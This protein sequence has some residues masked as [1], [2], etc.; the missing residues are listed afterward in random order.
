MVSKYL[1]SL[2]FLLYPA[3]CLGCLPYSSV[4]CYAI[5]FRSVRFSFSEMINKNKEVKFN[6]LVQWCSISC[7]FIRPLCLHALCATVL[8]LWLHC[9][10]QPCL[11]VYLAFATKFLLMSDLLS[12]RLKMSPCITGSLQTPRRTDDMCDV[13]EV[14]SLHGK[15]LTNTSLNVYPCV[16]R[17]WDPFLHTAGPWLFTHMQCKKKLTC[18]PRGCVCVTSLFTPRFLTAGSWP[19]HRPTCGRPPAWVWPSH[20]LSSGPPC[21]C[22]LPPSSKT[23]VGYGVEPPSMSLLFSSASTEILY[24]LA[25]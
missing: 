20:C 25:W 18:L 17:H 15:F 9:V 12:A 22:P 8:Q 13:I 21:E 5:L 4:M 11:S 16:W 24:C 7:T 23:T 3:A 14:F 2:T 6:I 19:T 10:Q 1:D